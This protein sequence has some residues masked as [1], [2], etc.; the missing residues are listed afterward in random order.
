MMKKIVAALLA[1][2]L[3]LAPFSGCSVKTAQEQ[4]DSE[5]VE[6]KAAPIDEKPITAQIINVLEYSGVTEVTAGGVTMSAYKGMRL[7]E[8]DKLTTGDNSSA[9]LDLNNGGYVEV[10]YDSEIEILKSKADYIEIH[11]ISGSIINNIEKGKGQYAVKAN[12][13]TMGVLGTVF[14][15]N[16]RNDG[17]G[18]IE[19][20]EGRVSVS[21]NNITIESHTLSPGEA[22]S[23]GDDGSSETTE[24]DLRGLSDDELTI[25]REMLEKRT[26]GEAGAELRRVIDGITGEQERRQRPTPTPA[27]AP[28]QAPIQ[29]PPAPVPTPS[30]TPVPVLTAGTPTLTDA[31]LTM[32]WTANVT[33]YSFGYYWSDASLNED[34]RPVNIGSQTY[35]ILASG[36]VSSPMEALFDKVKPG[37][38]VLNAALIDETAGKVVATGTGRVSAP[39]ISA[40]LVSL[41]DITSSSKVVVQMTPLPTASGVQYS[42]TTPSASLPIVL[43]GANSF[44]Y[45]NESAEALGD[46]IETE[47]LRAA[48]SPI[49]EGSASG[50][51][52]S[53]ILYID[54]VTICSAT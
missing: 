48:D 53:A 25:I 40:G 18:K 3:L 30:P 47:M 20:F 15:V 41:T 52:S 39:V 44:T 14:R 22:Y 19:L 50:S 12:N 16:V 35:Y 9:R 13:V 45:E 27:P 29:A 32:S 31:A 1:L 42:G 5:I 7:S 33:T 51:D 36:T 28:I 10:E 6:T 21:A 37:P 24:I 54:S 34:G 46:I 11:L 38:V 17:K 4:G 43:N 2:L 49:G 23:W 8:G 26:G